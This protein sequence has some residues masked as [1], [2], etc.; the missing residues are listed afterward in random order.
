MIGAM[1]DDHKDLPPNINTLC[2][3]FLSQPSLPN[4]FYPEVQ[5]PSRLDSR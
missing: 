4:V 5:S 1:S 3:E 2:R